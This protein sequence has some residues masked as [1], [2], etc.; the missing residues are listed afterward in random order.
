MLEMAKIYYTSFMEKDI[1]LHNVEA[2]NSFKVQNLSM[3]EEM[4]QIQ[5]LFCDKTGTLTKNM[6]VFREMN[7]KSEQG[8]NIQKS[9]DATPDNSV[10][11]QS[12]KLPPSRQLDELLRCILICHDVLRI[13]GK[14]SG[15][16]QD[17]LVLMEMVEKE[18]G[19]LFKNRDACFAFLPFKSSSCML[20]V[21]VY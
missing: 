9:I 20:S 10:K 13:D 14:L 18:Y 15:S 19:A 21:L 17:E 8:E 7:V 3:H 11:G 1:E 16:S 6:L 2:G 4:G 12:K 5:Y